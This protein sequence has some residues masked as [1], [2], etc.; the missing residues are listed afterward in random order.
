M[1]QFQIVVLNLHI[2]YISVL[3]LFFRAPNEDSSVDKERMSVGGQWG[4]FFLFSFFIG[5]NCSE[6]GLLK[7]CETLRFNG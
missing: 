3:D 2:I 5:S 7:C 6:V 4:G 1:C